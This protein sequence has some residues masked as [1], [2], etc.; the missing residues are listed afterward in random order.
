MLLLLI[1]G[2][3]DN[4]CFSY[5]RLFSFV[6]CLRLCCLCTL[7]VFVVTWVLLFVLCGG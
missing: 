6:D 5:R 2:L 7:L 4:W 1:F 3:L